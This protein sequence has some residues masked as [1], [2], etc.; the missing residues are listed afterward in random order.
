MLISQT[1]AAERRFLTTQVA[2]AILPCPSHMTKHC[3]LHSLGLLCGW[4]LLDAFVAVQVAAIQP[5]DVS[6][7]ASAMSRI[8]EH[9]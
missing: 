4:T 5:I 6:I 7:C 2:F 3:R 1:S 9:A 8:G